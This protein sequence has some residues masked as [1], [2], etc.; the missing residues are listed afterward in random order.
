MSSFRWLQE[1]SLDSGILLWHLHAAFSEEKEERGEKQKEIE[2]EEGKME[3]SEKEKTSSVDEERE[4]K[5]KQRSSSRQLVALLCEG[6]TRAFQL[7]KRIL[8]EDFFQSNV[9]ASKSNIS[10]AECQDYQSISRKKGRFE[11]I[12]EIIK[13]QLELDKS[14]RPKNA[15]LNP[16]QK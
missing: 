9:S 14:Q 6:N 7:F 13:R 11:A 10:K 5:E 1:K 8:P 4:R 16:V 3:K 15:R 12:S 2:G